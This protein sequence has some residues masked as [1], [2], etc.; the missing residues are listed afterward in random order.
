MT[1]RTVTIELTGDQAALLDE[2]AAGRE[3]DPHALLLEAV[4]HGLAMIVAGVDES[5]LDH[6]E[7]RQTYHPLSSGDFARPAPQPHGGDL[8]D[9]I[10]F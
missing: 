9:E 2:I 1:G 4:A 7:D 3:V 5:D 10:P 8:E 6:P